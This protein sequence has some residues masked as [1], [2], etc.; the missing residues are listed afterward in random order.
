[1][2]NLS[3]IN[4]KFIVEDSGDVGIGVTTATTKLHI[5]GTAPGDSIIRQDSTVSGTN[6]EIG[7]RA[8]GKWQIF[9]DD[10]DTIVATFM[11]SGNVGI[12]TETPGA[13][14][15]VAVADSSSILEL[16]RTGSASFSTLISDIGAGA[17]QLWFNADT[18]DTGFLFRPR[19]SAGNPNNAFLIAPTGNVGIGTTSPTGK[20][21]SYI[22]ATRQLT[23]NGNGGDLSIISDNNSSPVM[24]IKGTGSADLLNVFDNTT[25]VFTIL[26]GGNV[27]IGIT[28]NNGY[29]LDV[30][31]ATEALFR[32]RTSN[33]TGNGGV[34]IGNGDRN[35]A[36]LVRHSQAESFE[37]RDETANETRLAIDSSG[38][39][40][41]TG[42]TSLST[43]IA[44]IQHLSSNGYLYIK[45]GSGGLIIGDDSTSSR[46]QIEDN[47]NIRFETAGTERMRIDSS[48]DVGI[49]TTP[50]TAGPTW[51]TLFVGASATIVSRQA[52]AGYDSMFANNYYVNSSNQDRVR[53]TGPSSRMFLDGNN[54]RFQISPSTGA[55]GSPTWSEI[56]RIDDSGNVGIG[57]TSPETELSIGNYT[58]STETITIATLDNGTGR[59]NFYDNNNTE[60]GSIRVVGELGGSKMYFSNRWNTDNDRV[61]FDLKNGYVGIGTT[62]PITKL[63]V[64]NSTETTGITDVLTVTC[65]T[66]NTASAGKG[67]AIRIG[68][69]PDGNYSTKI[70]TVYEQSNPSYL[71]PAMVF[72]TMYNSYLK[73]S[74][75]ERMRITSTGY[76][77]ASDN[78]NYFSSSG[79][80]HELNQTTGGQWNTIIHNNTAAPYGL[81]INY[82][83]AAP[84]SGGSEFLYCA[85][86]STQRFYV[87]SAG[88]VY[89]N[90]TYGT[91][92]DKKLKENIEDATTKLDDINKL[93]VRNF[94]FKDKPEEKHIGFIAQ[95]FEEVFPK[96]IENTQDRDEDNNLI[97]DSYTKTIKTSI[98]IP[99]LVKSIQ[100]LKA[101]NDILKSRIETLENK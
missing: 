70:A 66:T 54:I 23:H 31:D 100:E 52:A 56:M 57:T 4:N 73:G 1:M 12:G 5:G 17:A 41:F 50:E 55:G 13:K 62:S 20:F 98:L 44:S 92:S 8:A 2:A 26:D 11:S 36:M 3:N 34:Y 16:T 42:S 53:T 49:G 37:I 91:I 32:I 78:G 35:W 97:E 90:G 6:W 71:N 93:K 99:M 94:N 47:S 38:A 79:L 89:G 75:I 46:I 14:L 40:S 9:E 84:N 74:E 22:S 33:A 95:E 80:Y 25:E 96:A 85:D 24:F 81:Y 61:V 29:K 21:N 63:S 10:G 45:G 77:K 19:D 86:S 51:R 64:H 68:R 58:D 15:E 27:G 69:D 59:I 30:F 43:A 72:Y 18:N 7:E 39:T 65:A 82:S 87:T 101:D 48:G 60:G 28:P 83:S 67:A 88:A 76:L